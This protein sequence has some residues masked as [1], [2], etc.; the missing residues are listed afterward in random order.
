MPSLSAENIERIGAVLW[1]GS[2]LERNRADLGAI[3]VADDDPMA[4]AATL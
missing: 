1:S 4:G 3:A 2:R